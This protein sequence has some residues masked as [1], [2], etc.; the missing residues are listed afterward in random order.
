MI[1][2]PDTNTLLPQTYTHN[3]STVYYFPAVGVPMVRLD[4]LHEAGSAYQPQPLCAAAVNRL[5]SVASTT[6]TSAEVAEF[7]DYRGIIVE[8]DPDLLTSRTTFYFLRRYLDELLPVIQEL[9]TTPAFPQADFDAY[10][11]KRRQEMQAMRQQSSFVARRLFYQTLFAPD[12]PLAR[13]AD[14]VD[15]DRL[16][17]DVVMDFFSERYKGCQ[18]IISGDVDDDLLCKVSALSGRAIPNNIER[19]APSCDNIAGISQHAAIDGAV[20]TTLRVGRVI[21]LGWDHP[22]YARLML[23]VTLLGGYFGSRLMSNLREEKGLTYGVQARTQIYRGLIVFYIVTDVAAG[24]ADVAEEAV[25]Y[26]LQRL[27]DELIGE[28]ELQ[29]VKTVLVGDFIR[30]VDGVFERAQRYGQMW[31]THVD[32]RFTDN[33][34]AAVADTTAQQLRNLAQQYLTPETM[35]YC[36]AGA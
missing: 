3:G 26:E 36:R 7:M 15:A 5:F 35:I 8:N 25:R 2:L 22:D 20:Q 9:L 17:R 31:T 34:R 28:D 33:L 6:R 29:L 14:P 19:L 16:G 13:Y 23:L 4:L 11:K 10:L 12:H 1:S 27:S 32:E 21:P 24:T 18:L 30:S